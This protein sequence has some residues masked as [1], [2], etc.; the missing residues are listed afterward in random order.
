M[1]SGMLGVAAL[2]GASVAG[3]ASVVRARAAAAAA[4]ADFMKGEERVYVVTGG[5][6][7]I[8]KAIATQLAGFSDKW[9]VV[10]TAR[11]EKAAQ[12]AVA[13]IGESA[14]AVG[15]V[16]GVV[17]DVTDA[18]GP[19]KVV[20]YLN[21]TLEGRCDGLVNNAGVFLEAVGSTLDDVTVETMR[22]T[23][24]V[25]VFG[26]LAMTKALLPLMVANGFGRIVTVG[27]RAGQITDMTAGGGW[28]MAYRSSKAAVNK[29]VRNF[30]FHIANDPAYAGVDITCNVCCPGF[31]VRFPIRARARMC[32]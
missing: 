28:F 11:S 3:I 5:N 7:G 23:Y 26:V 15:R 17:A 10:V 32:V 13:E 9:V 20:E 1:M 24:E 22:A 25:N 29:V 19:G 21:Q 31:I 6:R 18:D 12:E 2:V 8:G 4:A 14:G 27:S 30:A 16:H